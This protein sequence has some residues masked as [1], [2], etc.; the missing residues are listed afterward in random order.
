MQQQLQELKKGTD[1]GTESLMDRA[2]WGLEY[3]GG[4]GDDLESV[5]SYSD[6]FNQG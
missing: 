4:R 2:L 5:T 3:K 1:L 6:S